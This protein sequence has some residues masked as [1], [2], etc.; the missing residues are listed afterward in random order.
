[1]TNL[2]RAGLARMS[3][4]TYAPFPTVYDGLFPNGTSLTAPTK[5]SARPIDVVPGS[6]ERPATSEHEGAQTARVVHD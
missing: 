2:V 6:A 1:M 3:G 4:A 5:R